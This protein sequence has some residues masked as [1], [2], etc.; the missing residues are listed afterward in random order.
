MWNGIMYMQDIQFFKTDYIY[1]LTGQG[2]FVRRVIEQ[3][4]VAYRYFMIKQVGREKVEPGRLTVGNKMYL[5]AFIGQCLAQF[6]GYH[7]TTTK[8]RVTNNTYF[9]FEII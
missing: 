5:M 1:E 8:S 3:R 7:T 2:R 9:H 6:S 4:I